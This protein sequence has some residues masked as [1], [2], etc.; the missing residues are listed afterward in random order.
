MILCLC[1]GVAER[2]VDA[3]IAGGASS[4]D[5]VMDACAAGTDCGACHVS[6]LAL[7]GRRAGHARHPEHAGQR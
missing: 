5:D 6:I 1:R 7:L 4:V 2:I 3:A